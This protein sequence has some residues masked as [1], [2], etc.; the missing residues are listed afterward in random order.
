M[1]IKNVSRRNDFL[2]CV[3]QAQSHIWRMDLKAW[4]QNEERSNVE[5]ADLLS[6]DV[7]TIKNIVAGRRKPSPGLAFRIER[8]TQGRVKAKS[9]YPES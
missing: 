1:S 2:A 4:M 5:M 9:F 3:G 6:V 8:V 7:S